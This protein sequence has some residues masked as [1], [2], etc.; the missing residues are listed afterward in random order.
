[1]PLSLCSPGFGWNWIVSQ[2]LT[3]QGAQA[4]RARPTDQVHVGLAREPVQ[5]KLWQLGA[6]NGE[7]VHGAP[8]RAALIFSASLASRSGSSIQCP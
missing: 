2:E 8:H 6:A 7:S 4:G 1:M 5:H 3:A